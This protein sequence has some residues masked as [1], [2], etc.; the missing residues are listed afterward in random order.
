MAK[1]MREG[2]EETPQKRSLKFDFLLKIGIRIKMKY[3]KR[4]RDKLNLT[5]HFTSMGSSTLSSM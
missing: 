5:F 3:I 4:S 2:S 1:E